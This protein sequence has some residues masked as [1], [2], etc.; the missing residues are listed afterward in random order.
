[1]RAIPLLLLALS[2]GLAACEPDP[3]LSPYTQAV[4]QARFDKDMAFRDPERSILEKRD[5]ERFT[6]LRYFD[7]DSTYRYAL[8]L[9][10]AERVDTLRARLRKGGSDRYLRIGT[11]TLD[12]G[13][14]AETLAVF[15]PADGRDVL[16][17]PFTDGTTGKESYGGGRYLNP[18]LRA[19][20]TILVDFNQA[21]NPDCDYNPERFNCALP[22]SE[23]RLRVALQVGEKKSLLH[24]PR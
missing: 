14:V 8:P 1:M 21:Y 2:V 18:R 13:G 6:G 11:V 12:V 24:E 7:V 9:Q 4:L 22:P 20:G 23:N 17:L 10:P 3:T 19:D 16:W 15:R 5:R